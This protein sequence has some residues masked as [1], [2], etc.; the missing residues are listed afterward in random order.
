MLYKLVT[1][2]SKLKSPIDKRPELFCGLR[3]LSESKSVAGQAK[4][5]ISLQYDNR[6]KIPFLCRK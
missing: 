4:R 1:G 2:N 6:K 5:V 3:V